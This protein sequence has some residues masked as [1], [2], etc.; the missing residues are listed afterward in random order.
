MKGKFIKYRDD[1]KFLNKFLSNIVEQGYCFESESFEKLFNNFVSFAEDKT[2]LHDY[3]FRYAWWLYVMDQ[4]EIDNYME[5]VIE[6][7][8]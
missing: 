7:M 3:D 4:I 5:K 2:A 1:R 8:Q 6:E